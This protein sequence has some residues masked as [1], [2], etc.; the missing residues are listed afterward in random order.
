MSKRIIIGIISFFLIVFLLNSIRCGFSTRNFVESIIASAI[1]FIF[2][3]FF[4]N[5]KQIRIEDCTFGSIDY[6]KQP[7][8]VHCSIFVT[9]TNI[10]KMM[11][12]TRP[13]SATSPNCKPFY[14]WFGEYCVYSRVALQP[15]PTVGLQSNG[16]LCTDSRYLQVQRTTLP[17]NKKYEKIKI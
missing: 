6:K 5:K 7:P 2:L 1:F 12:V 17:N 10:R 14:W 13:Q 4:R 11:K 8:K 16:S 3:F 9:H 15:F